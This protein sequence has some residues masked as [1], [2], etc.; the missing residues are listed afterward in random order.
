M[1]RFS[2]LPLHITNRLI[3]L[4]TRVQAK[5]QK[6]PGAEPIQSDSDR[7]LNQPIAALPSIAGPHMIETEPYKKLFYIMEERGV[8]VI[9]NH[10]YYPVPDITQTMISDPWKSDSA[11][12]G[13]DMNLTTQLDLLNKAFPAYQDEYNLLPQEKTA[14]LPPYAFH[15]R[16]GIFDG[17]DALVLYCMV[18]HFKPQRIIEVGSGWSTRISAQAALKNGHTR[19]TSIEPYPA[20]FLVDGFPGLDSLFVKKVQDVDFS[21]FETLR[22]GDI[23]FIDTSHVIKTGGDVIYL[24]LE[25]LPRL[26]KGVVIHIHDIFFPQDYPKWWMKELV[27]FWDEQYL[28]HAFLTFNSHFRVLFANNYMRLKCQDQIKAVFPKS[29]FHDFACSFWMQKTL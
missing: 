20:P 25:V 11:L 7:M 27:R 16:N 23:L 10:F 1:S 21:L 3:R 22:E 29:P 8:H 5:L 26:N 19:L 13:I 12:I 18:R 6:V 24:Y 17:L 15:F 14:S 9:P 2:N 4:L 28:L